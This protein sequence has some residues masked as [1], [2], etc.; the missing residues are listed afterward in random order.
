MG[1][2]TYNLKNTQIENI[3]ESVI[4]YHGVRFIIFTTHLQFLVKGSR[5]ILT[6]LT[7]CDKE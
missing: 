5:E 6:I 2:I 3:T 4:I 1:K 7:K